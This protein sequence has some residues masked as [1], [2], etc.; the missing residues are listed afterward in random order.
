MRELQLQMNRDREIY[1]REWRA[2]DE[3]KRRIAQEVRRLS[4]E[5]RGL[6]GTA[7]S[8]PDIA[9]M[10][11]DL[12]RDFEADAKSFASHWDIDPEARKTEL[13]DS[14]SR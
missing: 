5:R 13:L 14:L 8:A 3:T 7:G 10:I 9:G 12:D 6:A 2:L 1:D 11:D 4:Q